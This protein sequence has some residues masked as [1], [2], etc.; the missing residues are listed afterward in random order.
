MATEE[1]VTDEAISARPVEAR[2]AESERKAAAEASR[3]T[4]EE[5]PSP[6]P[7]KPVVDEANFAEAAENA[8]SSSC[9]TPQR[10]VSRRFSGIDALDDVALDTSAILGEHV[11]DP[12]VRYEKETEVGRGQYGKVFIAKDLECP[13]RKVAIK[14]VVLAVNNSVQATRIRTEVATM[15]KLTHPNICKLFETYQQ[16]RFMFLVMELCTGGEVFER[17]EDEAVIDEDTARDIVWQVASALNY[18]HANGIAH[19][20]LKAENICFVNKADT[21]VQV[22]DWGVAAWFDNGTKRMHSAMG[23]ECYV[24]PEVFEASSDVPCIAAC[25]NFSLGVLLCVMLTGTYP[26]NASTASALDQLAAKKREDCDMSTKEWATVSTEAKHL[27]KALL[28]AKPEER[29]PIKDVLLHAWLTKVQDRKADAQVLS[30]VLGNMRRFSSTTQFFVI[31]A[32]TIVRHTE[33]QKLK[34]IHRVFVELDTNNDGVLQLEEIKDGFKRIFGEHSQELNEV[35]DAFSNLDLD[36]SGTLNYT[37]FCAGSISAQ[38]FLHDE[39]A[40]R[41]AFRS[42]DTDNDG[43]ISKSEFLSVLQKVDVNQTFS[44]SMYELAAAEILEQHDT[45]GDGQIDYQEWLTM[46][47]DMVVS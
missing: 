17:I 18:A 11:G 32:T 6:W 12:W 22:I 13:T 44:D 38:D 43:Y 31:C 3:E 28:K 33:H 23:S 25:D 4:R 7:V 37:E 26:F 2:A 47:Q 36:R 5:L 40:L 15:K 20:D 27:I 39:T 45:N 1:G 42:F 8:A 19:R 16:G 35:T 24:A 29:L 41:S 9:S 46:V 10:K 14:R 34:D 21:F 30:S